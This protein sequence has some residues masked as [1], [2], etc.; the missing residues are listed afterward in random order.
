MAAPNHFKS[1]TQL[2]DGTVELQ[3]VDDDGDGRPDTKH[4]TTITIDA[5]CATDLANALCARP[6]LGLRYH[7][8]VTSEK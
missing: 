5:L 2:P 7:D 4:R 8:P 1:L 3:F 6:N